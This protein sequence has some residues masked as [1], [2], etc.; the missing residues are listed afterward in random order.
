M[1]ENKK[2]LFTKRRKCGKMILYHL[3]D[4]ENRFCAVSSPAVSRHA[5]R[6]GGNMEETLRYKRV[7]IKLSGEALATGVK[8]GILNYDFV[9]Q[10][11][12]AIKEIYA[13][14]KTFQ[15]VQQ[16]NLFC[17]VLCCEKFLGLLEIH[18]F[19]FERKVL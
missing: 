18:L 3:A 15:T 13:V 11:C 8:D 19:L 1:R 17:L 5:A 7:L 6:R 2:S 16:M 9:R 14:C 4:V 12:L 10:I